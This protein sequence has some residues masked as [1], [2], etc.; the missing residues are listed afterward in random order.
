MGTMSAIDRRQSTQWAISNVESAGMILASRTVYDL[1]NLHTFRAHRMII[2]GAGLSFK[3]PVSGS[4]TADDY[5]PFDTPRPVNFDDFSGKG[6]RETSASLGLYSIAYLTIFNGSAYFSSV[7]ARAKWSGW[8]LSIPGGGF[9]HGVTEVVYG[10]GN[11][12]GTVSVESAAEIDLPPSPETL[13]PNIRITQKDDALVIRI[14]G[15]VLFDFDKAIIKAVAER[16]LTQAGA[17]IRSNRP[18][19]I[20]IDGHTD[21]KGDASYNIGLSNRRAN[22]VADWFISKGYAKVA[23]VKTQGWGKSKP[24]VPNTRPDGSDDEIG[25]AKNR[26]VEIFL[27]K[28]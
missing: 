4:F 25:R 2:G 9:D 23:D 8:G 19:R 18:R 24:E 17:I 13:S 3:L 21:S 28:R 12:L 10:D 1:V 14:H 26:R 16:D 20:E 27:I 15:D 11:S 5:E 22:A 7:L 6:A